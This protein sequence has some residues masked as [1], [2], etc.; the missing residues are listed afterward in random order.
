MRSIY[1]D[2]AA[3]TFPKPEKVYEAI[4]YF[5]RHAGG[6]PGRGSN[7]AALQ[8]GS[9]LLE[10]RDA[11]AELFNIRDSSRI[12]FTINITDAINTAVKGILKPG[13]HVISSSM[14]HNAIARPLYVMNRERGVE[15]T[16]VP[17]A[18]DGSLDPEDVRKAIRPNTRMIAMLHASNLTGTIMPAEEIGK[19]AREYEVI[20]VLDTAQSAGVLPINVD[21][22]CIDILTFTGHKGLLGPQGTGGIYIRPGLDI[23]PLKQGGTGSLSEYLE[24][25]Q[26]MPDLLESGTHNTPGIAGLL[27]GVNY[28][29]DRGLTDIH[30]HEQG[31][32]EMLFNGLK[33]IPDV[34][35]YG[36]SDSNNRTAVVAFNIDEMDCGEVSVNLDY[37]YGIVT[38]S[39]L[40]CAPLAHRTLGTFESGSCR[41]SPGIFNTSEDIEIILRAV[42]EIAV[43]HK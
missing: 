29:M 26:F 12:A 43:Q 9:L 3:T 7:K 1:V 37:K 31:L 41:I 34:S 17:C 4:D 27:A 15:W 25:P 30:R 32:T 39:G 16:V 38:R 21:E 42:H 8:A 19:I 22:Q 2:N 23:N 40:H 10:C 14:E 35:V 28:I 33:E 36:P 11:L 13:D 6:N 20:F 5:N 18:G 24:H